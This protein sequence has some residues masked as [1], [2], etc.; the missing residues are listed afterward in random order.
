M[1]LGL[2]MLRLSLALP[3]LCHLMVSSP[4]LWILSG[5]HPLSATVV[6]RTKVGHTLLLE[7]PEYIFFSRNDSLM[8][9]K[10]PPE[11]FNASNKHMFRHLFS[12]VVQIQNPNP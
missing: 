1:Y 4:S 10:Y 6:G 5:E 7:I 12:Y 3:C 2:H 11:E 9:D 8:P